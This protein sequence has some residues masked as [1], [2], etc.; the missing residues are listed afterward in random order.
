TVSRRATR[1]SSRGP[2][3]VSVFVVGWST[4]S[5]VGRFAINGLLS[6]GSRSSVLLRGWGSGAS[7]RCSS[8]IVRVDPFPWSGPGGRLRGR[9]GSGLVA[10][11]LGIEGFEDPR[12]QP[13]LQL[14]QEPDAGEVD[15]AL[16]GQMADPG[17]ATNVL[18][19]V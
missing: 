15:A 2:P 8:P 9:F 6:I 10:R 1:G 11:P 5:S 13:F 4:R 3:V 14:E 12:A 17:D 16:A 19:A 18:V 7:G